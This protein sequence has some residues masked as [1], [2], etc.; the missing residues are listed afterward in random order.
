[1]CVLVRVHVHV[2]SHFLVAKSVKVI[3]ASLDQ[4]IVFK[5]SFFFCLK[6]YT[7]FSTL[8]GVA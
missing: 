7:I 5:E 1:V 4:V 8:L 3:S 6:K 2:H